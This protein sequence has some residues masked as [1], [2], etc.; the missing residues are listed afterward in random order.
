M[1]KSPVL[2][3]IGVLN[4]DRSERISDRY[5]I[6]CLFPC[7]GGY[8]GNAGT[9]IGRFAAIGATSYEPLAG[10]RGRL[11]A[12]VKEAREST[13]IGDLF[14]GIFPRTPKEGAEIELGN[15]ILV[16]E[17]TP[18]GKGVGVRPDIE[19]RFPWMNLRALYDCHD[20]TVEIWFNPNDGQQSSAL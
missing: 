19:T 6:V 16:F 13:H 12:V 8:N 14:H 4:W 9:P 17:D 2:I 1:K 18:Q 20:Q 15:G 11:V 7:A 10:T 5:G 3:G